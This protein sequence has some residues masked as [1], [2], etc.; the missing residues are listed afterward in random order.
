MK[1]LAIIPARGGSK[2]IPHK[3]IINLAGYPLI[4]YVISELLKTER[5][6]KIIVSTDD[7]KIKNTVFDYFKNEVEVLDR[8]E[9]ISNDT[10]TSES[11]IDHVIKNTKEKYDYILF[12]QCTSPL[13][14]SSDFNNLID[15]IELGFD[16][17]CFYIDDYGTIFDIDEATKARLPRQKKTPRKREAGNAWIFKTTEFLINKSRL[18]GKISL[19]K[20]NPP[21]HLEIDE[22]EDLNLMNYLLQLRNLKDLKNKTIYIDIDNTICFTKK[23]DY[24]NAIPNYEMINKFNELSKNNT[25][26]YYT[27]RGT[28]TGINHF[29][30]TKNQLDKWNVIYD[31]LK[32]GKPFFDVYIDDKSFSIIN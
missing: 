27:A 17:A 6:N 8:P 1:I 4:Y 9:E 32:L 29:S 10:A 18:F 24:Q 20:I 19:C 2:G 23:D 13:T 22:P 28:T 30:I 12:V 14:E 7:N 25:I 5:V 16:S 3:N 31:R 26:I 15:N 21:K 11:V